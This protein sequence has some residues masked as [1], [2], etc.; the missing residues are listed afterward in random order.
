[1]DPWINGS[2]DPW[3]YD[4]RGPLTRGLQREF[5]RGPRGSQEAPGDPR[6]PQAAFWVRPSLPKRLPVEWFDGVW[7]QF[8]PN[9]AQEPFRAADHDDSRFRGPPLWPAASNREEKDL[10]TLLEV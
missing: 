7:M 6:R 1:M 2:V 3:I 8:A 10:D 4:F 5:P 9:L